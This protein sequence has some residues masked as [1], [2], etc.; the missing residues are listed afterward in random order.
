MIE[1]LVFTVSNHSFAVR[2]EE[3]ERVFAAVQIT[4]LPGAPTQVLGVVNIHGSITPVVDPRILLGWP[5][6]DVHA[7]QSL[8]LVVI[9]DSPLLLLVDTVL[10]V[11]H[12]SMFDMPSLVK[13]LELF[14]GMIK[15][16]DGVVFIYDLEGFL[17]QK[18]QDAL[19]TALSLL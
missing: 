2:V 9:R 8:I 1:V 14:G 6:R 3:V 16:E 15:I 7:D 11:S 12:S 18:D 10:G 4:E 13:D 19:Q 5:S 17:S